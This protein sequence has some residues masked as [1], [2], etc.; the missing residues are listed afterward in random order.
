MKEEDKKV[1]QI[2]KFFV[3]YLRSFQRI[4]ILKNIIILQLYMGLE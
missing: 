1:Q 3:W 4:F 2:R